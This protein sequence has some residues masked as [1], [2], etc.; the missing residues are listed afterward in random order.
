MEIGQCNLIHAN[1]DKTEYNMR[2]GA[3][4]HNLRLSVFS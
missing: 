1:F 2:F 4:F 3:S